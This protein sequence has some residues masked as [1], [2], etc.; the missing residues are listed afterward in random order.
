MRSRSPHL[1]RVHKIMCESCDSNAM[2][3][4]SGRRRFLRLAGLGAGALLLAGALP[5][6]I[7]RAAEKTAPPPNRK[8]PS[9]PTRPC[10]D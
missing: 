10:N 6:K 8:T 5:D 9:A 7:A 4:A 2:Q 1:T 3:N